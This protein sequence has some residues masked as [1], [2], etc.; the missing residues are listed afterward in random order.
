[1]RAIQKAVIFTVSIFSISV[2]HSFLKT[3]IV[4]Q[5]IKN[6]P[7]L[8]DMTRH[9]YIHK[10]SPIGQVISQLIPLHMLSLFLWP[11]KADWLR[12]APTNLTFYN[13]TLSAH[14]I[15]V[16]WIYLRTNSDLCHLQHKL[17]GFYNREEK[18][19]QRGMD[20]VFKESGLRFVFNALTHWH[21]IR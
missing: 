3:Q 6:W 19:L 20:W 18:C 13:C 15:Y 9:Y 5:P 12:D 17:I 1:M 4:N 8:R 2:P 21:F 10:N 16:I 14:C 7:L 11:F